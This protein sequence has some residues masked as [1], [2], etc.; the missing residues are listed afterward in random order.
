M[1]TS[2]GR[3]NARSIARRNDVTE[4][5]LRHRKALWRFSVV[6]VLPALACLCSPAAFAQWS[7]SATASFGMGL[8]SIALG[9][10]I[11]SGTRRLSD[12]KRPTT[13]ATVPANVALLNRM[14][15]AEIDAALG[16]RPD[17]QVS[18]K[19]RDELI[20]IISGQKPALRPVLEKAFAN[21]AVLQQFE[22]F[23]VAHG[24]S[25]HNVADAV[26]ALL[27]SSWQIVHGTTLT[28]AQIRG[29]HQQIRAILLGSPGLR[30]MTSASRQRVAEAMAYL[31]IVEADSMRSSDPVLLDQAQQNASGHVKNLLGLD[32]ARLE[33]TAN[34]GFR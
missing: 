11:L 2:A 16:Y 21:D 12:P 1:R 20:E 25:S 27:W 29:V 3:P 14:T 8:G 10:S 22:R 26:A 17:P 15:P 23:I 32:L 19:L 28:D 6:V 18:M 34:G 13:P 9:Q 31:V 30:S 33:V 7:P 4:P 5:K 24:Y